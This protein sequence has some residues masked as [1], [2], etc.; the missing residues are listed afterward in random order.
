MTQYEKLIDIFNIFIKLFSKENISRQAARKRAIIGTNAKG[1]LSSVHTGGS[2]LN[3]VVQQTCKFYVDDENKI[4]AGNRGV[5]PIPFSFFMYAQY[6]RGQQLL[7]LSTAEKSRREKQLKQLFPVSLLCTNRESQNVLNATRRQQWRGVREQ[8]IKSSCKWISCR[9]NQM[10]NAFD[11]TAKNKMIVWG[12]VSNW[13][14]DLPISTTDRLYL[15]KSKEFQIDLSWL[16]PNSDIDQPREKRSQVGMTHIKSSGQL[17]C[18][19]D[20]NFAE[21]VSFCVIALARQQL[22]PAAPVYWRLTVSCSIPSFLL[23]SHQSVCVLCC[24]LFKKKIK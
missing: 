11:I 2:S 23:F 6:H 17:C 24:W 21:P 5:F 7:L 12:N 4:K 19:G 13:K 15:S 20:S 16:A 10:V 1:S 14:R 18:R 3:C 8:T 22:L 9:S